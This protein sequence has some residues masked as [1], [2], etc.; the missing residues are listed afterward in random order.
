MIWCETRKGY[1]E[2]DWLCMGHLAEAEDELVTEYPDAAAVVRKNRTRYEMDRD[3]KPNFPQI[4]RY[5]V[6]KQKQIME[7]Q[8]R[9]LYGTEAPD[10]P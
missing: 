4:I 9:E 2:F 10:I 5:L 7:E 1:P 8:I 3:L 6:W